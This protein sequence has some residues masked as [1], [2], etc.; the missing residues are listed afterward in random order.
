MS[1]MGVYSREDGLRYSHARDR[2]DAE[3]EQKPSTKKSG[4]TSS[5]GPL[6]PCRDYH[7][8]MRKIDACNT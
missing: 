7:V 8:I 1:I 6:D 4:I 2:G 5:R 3:E